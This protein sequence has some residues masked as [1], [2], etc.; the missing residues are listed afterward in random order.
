M[1]LT[2]VGADVAAQQPWPGESFS[3]G[4]THTGQ[5]V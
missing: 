5:G 2:C 1:D 3:T 4:G